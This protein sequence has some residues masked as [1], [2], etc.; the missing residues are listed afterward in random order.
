MTWHIICQVG[1]EDVFMPSMEQS[2]LRLVVAI[3]KT[4]SPYLIRN[5]VMEVLQQSGLG[6]PP[7]L[8]V[9]L[10]HLAMAAY[11]AD[12]RVLRRT[13]ADRWTRDFLLHIP[14][15]DTTIW[16]A[17]LPTLTRM[18]SYLT[19]DR[20]DVQFRKR[21]IDDKASSSIAP[22]KAAD[23]DQPTVVSL[24][25]GGLDSF[26]GAIDL[27]ES[28]VQRIALVGQYGAGTAHAAQ[29]RA[30]EV[31]EKNYLN[32]ANH[33]LFFVQPFKGK[34]RDSEETMRSRSIL[35]LSLGAVVA[36]AIGP[37]T[38]LFVPENGLISL[39][40][41][42]TFARI[43]SLSTRTTHPH[44]MYLFRELLKTL[45]IDISLELP[46]RFQTKGEMLSS[47]KNPTV[48]RAG[49]P[50][51]M[52]CSRPD[53]ARFQGRAPGKHCG[54]CVP[55]LIRRSSMAAVALDRSEDYDFDVLRIEPKPTS[56]IG[57][58]FRAFDMA[59]ER[60]ANMRPF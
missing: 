24:F 7:D 18:L 50:V 58:D 56:P 14:V 9:D 1:N 57:K 33:L 5:H 46:Y 55:C 60:I 52:S 31:L 44:F 48:F 38:P 10:L 8:A 28:S 25:S 47:V 20:W 51:T 22:T 59:I 27:L 54:Y 30:Y 49:A 37:R 40:V 29:Q 19:G 53:A 3:A 16:S 21:R 2:D 32:R 11:T 17:A 12:V 42:L 39:N 13:A 6:A 15:S 35:F 23:S 45:S 26:V 41:P 4:G 34:N 36:S 43:G